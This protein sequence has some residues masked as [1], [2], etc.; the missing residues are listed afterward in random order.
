MVHFRYTAILL[1]QLVFIIICI[2]LTQNL[3]CQNELK[4]A[5]GTWL[6]ISGNNSIAKKWRIPTVGVIR[7]YNLAETTEFGFFRTGL[8]YAPNAKYNFTLGAAY[9]DT[10]PFDHDEFETLTTQVW[11]Y[12]E[13]CNST[14]LYNSKV[15]Q[16]FRL[17]QRWISKPTEDIFNLRLRYR[18]QFTKDLSEHLYIK[19]FDEPFLDFEQ[20]NINQNRFYLGLGRRITKNL[21]VEIGY[22][23]NHVGPNNFDRIRMVFLFKTTLYKKAKDNFVNVN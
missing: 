18:L 8:T 6:V 2:A 23:K 1:K 19:V 5:T 3:F 14:K 20:A 10:Q 22:M 12:Q 17:E 4:D 9:L 21:N 11:T 16:R 15:S 7:A 13:F